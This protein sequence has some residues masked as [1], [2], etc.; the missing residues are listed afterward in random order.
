MGTSYVEYGG[1]GFWSWDR[2]LE[3]AFALLA[4][5]TGNG[6]GHDRL[7]DACQ[8]WT[9]QASGIYGG[10]IDSNFDEILR[11]DARRQISPSNHRLRTRP[12]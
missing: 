9:E 12:K 6:D 3:D 8:H 2:Y 7:N 1:K 4:D 10:W 5:A 11:T